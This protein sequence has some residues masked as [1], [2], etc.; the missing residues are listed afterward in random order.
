MKKIFITVVACIF[1]IFSACSGQE[2]GIIEISTEEENVRSDVNPEGS[3]PEQIAV[4]ICGEV[5]TPGIY[6]LD[7]GSRI[8]DAV[9]AAGGALED[10]DLKNI[11]LAQRLSDGQQ[12]IVS[13][14]RKENTD[15]GE[16]ENVNTGTGKVNLNRAT[17]EELMTLPGIGESKADAILK[18]REEVGWISSTD[19]IMNISG[20]K[21]K[22]F[23]RISDLIEV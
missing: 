22:V 6:Y 18:Y 13:T 19:E 16:T 17:K 11:N 7:D 2:K 20:I 10:A 23:E 1:L 3:K 5:K 21:E 9:E 15:T 12:I 14:V 8:A 4:Y